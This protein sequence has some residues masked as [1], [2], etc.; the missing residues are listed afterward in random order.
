MEY[1]NFIISARKNFM[2]EP[3]KGEILRRLQPEFPKEKK[4]FFVYSI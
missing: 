2:E 1:N 3:N 4:N